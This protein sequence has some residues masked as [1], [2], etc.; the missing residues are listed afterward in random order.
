MS[1]GPGIPGPY[2]YVYVG[3]HSQ[4]AFLNIRY[5][6]HPCSVIICLT[7][8][9]LFVG[10]AAQVILLQYTLLYTLQILLICKGTSLLRPHRKGGT[11]APH[12]GGRY[13]VF[14]HPTGEGVIHL[15]PLPFL[16]PSPSSPLPPPHLPLSSSSPRFCAW[17]MMP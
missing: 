12:W 13:F 9:S 2:P 8:C 3:R 17:F 4:G 14:M 7:Y 10:G 16:T 6:Y 15:S 11:H 5:M 1:Q